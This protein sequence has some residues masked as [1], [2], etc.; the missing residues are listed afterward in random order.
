MDWSHC[1]SVRLGSPCPSP[2]PWWSCRYDRSCGWLSST[3]ACLPW[4]PPEPFPVHSLKAPSLSP[5]DPRS[6]TSQTCKS[7]KCIN[8]IR[9]HTALWTKYLTVLLNI[10]FQFFQFFFLQSQQ[11]LLLLQLWAGVTQQVNL[12]FGDLLILKYN[13][14]YLL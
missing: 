14:T 11:L 1:L 2:A 9:A 7:D 12:F 8:H 13:T 4:T 5:Q 3:G 10:V 6:Y